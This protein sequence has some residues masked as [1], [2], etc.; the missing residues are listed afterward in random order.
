M[1]PNG[2]PYKILA[3]A[4]VG[5]A[6]IAAALFANSKTKGAG[7]GALLG[8]AVYAGALW[9]SSAI[10]G[11]LLAAPAGSTGTLFLPRDGSLPRS[12]RGIAGEYYLP[13]DGGLPQFPRVGYID[14]RRSKVGLLDVQRMTGRY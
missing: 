3:L 11:K 6:P 8:G 14:A 12:I 5:A 1:N 2:T 9:A 7:K 13:R 10:M 4:V